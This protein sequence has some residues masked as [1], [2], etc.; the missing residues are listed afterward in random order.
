MSRWL[1][2]L[3]YG[4]APAYPRADYAY[5]KHGTIVKA[6]L[7]LFPLDPKEKFQGAP[8]F[9]D[10]KPARLLLVPKKF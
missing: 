2:Q 6:F 4:P 9:D 10:G 8:L 1:Y 5:K 3:S 7:T